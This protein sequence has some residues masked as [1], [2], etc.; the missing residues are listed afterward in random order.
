MS[1]AVKSY[2]LNLFLIRHPTFLMHILRAQRSYEDMIGH[3]SLNFAVSLKEITSQIILIDKETTIV[4]ISTTGLVSWRWY[5]EL[6]MTIDKR[7]KRAQE[8]N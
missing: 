1:G 2:F 5:L 6:T 4:P 8:E 7:D 3:F